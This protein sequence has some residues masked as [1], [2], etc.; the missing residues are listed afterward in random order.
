MTRFA[1][2]YPTLARSERIADGVMHALGITFAIT[3]AAL[4]IPFTAMR[5]EGNVTAAISVYCG[6]LIFA[7]VASALYHFPPREAARGVFR[8]IDQFAI[9]LKIAGT[10]TPITIIL[11][12]G[13]SIS[14]LWIIWAL[15]IA[16]GLTKLFLRVGPPWISPLLYLAAGWLSLAL[17]YPMATTLPPAAT[18]LVV[19]GGVLYTIGTGVLYLGKIRYITATWHAFVLAASGCLF[20]AVCVAAFA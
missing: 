3:G 13:L 17:L 20:A 8:R 6:I 1:V 11:G 4:L 7:F 12:T 9:W 14:V 16:G 18:I 15:A 5:G 19:I 2:T 10:Y